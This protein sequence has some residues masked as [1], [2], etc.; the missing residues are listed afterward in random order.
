MYDCPDELLPLQLFPETDLVEIPHAKTLISKYF[1]HK[2]VIQGLNAD[3]VK[4]MRFEGQN[5]ASASHWDKP[6]S[7]FNT[8]HIHHI[9]QLL[10][11]EDGWGN[12]GVLRNGTPKREVGT[13]QIASAIVLGAYD[14]FMGQRDPQL[15]FAVPCEYLDEFQQPTTPE[16]CV[17][18]S[19]YTGHATWNNSGKGCCYVAYTDDGLPPRWKE[20][21]ISEYAEFSREEREARIPLLSQVAADYAKWLDMTGGSDDVPA[22]IAGSLRTNFIVADNFTYGPFQPTVYGWLVPV[23]GVVTNASDHAIIGTQDVSDLEN[24]LSAVKVTVNGHTLSHHTERKYA[25]SISETGLGTGRGR[26]A[27]TSADPFYSRHAKDKRSGADTQIR[28]NKGVLEDRLTKRDLR[29]Y[30]SIGTPNYL[31]YPGKEGTL[32]KTAILSLEQRLSMVPG[33]TSLKKVLFRTSRPHEREIDVSIEGAAV[34]SGY[35]YPMPLFPVL[36]ASDVWHDIVEIAESYYDGLEPAQIL[37]LHVHA[38]PHRTPATCDELRNDGKPCESAE[39][40]PFYLMRAD[41]N[42]ACVR[43]EEII[44]VVHEASK[45]G[46]LKCPSCRQTIEPAWNF[47]KACDNPV[48]D[49]GF[50]DERAIF[51]ALC[52]EG[53]NCDA[54]IAYLNGLTGCD[55]AD[56]TTGVGLRHGDPETVPKGMSAFSTVSALVSVKTLSQPLAAETQPLHLF[57]MSREFFETYG[58]ERVFAHADPG[59]PKRAG[60]IHDLVSEIRKLGYSSYLEC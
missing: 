59:Y 27:Y 6:V 18:V 17:Y 13:R 3:M 14:E 45:L 2:D 20:C 19:A 11:V 31:I 58:C 57:M 52:A 38:K 42:H 53:H 35:N 54:Q 24:Q 10:R 22:T 16:V 25:N 21:P 1:V 34:V 9:L 8:M 49:S 4:H 12:G 56:E 28:F 55:I 51:R 43:I 39:G 41:E 48:T 26:P 36:I 15:G 29:I 44:D 50:E 60:D 40:V 37:K 30:R 33:G 5:P 46:K 32:S 47:C 7:P 23:S